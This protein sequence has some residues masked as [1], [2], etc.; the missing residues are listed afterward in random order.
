MTL[1]GVPLMW[2]YAGLT[3]GEVGVYQINAIVPFRSIPLG[4]DHTVDD[5]VREALQ[6]RF[7]S[8]WWIRNTYAE[9][10]PALI[11]AAL[12]VASTAPGAENWEFAGEA[13]YGFYRNVTAKSSAGTAKAGFG[14]GALFSAV[15]TQ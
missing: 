2:L 4:F 5:H 1:G 8:G 11:T 12:M 14:P 3:P 7:W 9:M 6:P 15:G 13:G 10:I